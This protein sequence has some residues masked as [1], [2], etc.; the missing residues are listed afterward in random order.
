MEETL[1]FLREH[2][3]IYVGVD[4]APGGLPRVSGARG[5]GGDR[6]LQHETVRRGSAERP[7]AG[8]GAEW[9]P[10][11]LDGDLMKDFVSPQLG[12]DTAA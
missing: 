6:A 1:W 5:R 4:E 3:L 8:E 11:P 12:A 7:Q 9:V 2:Q 10:A